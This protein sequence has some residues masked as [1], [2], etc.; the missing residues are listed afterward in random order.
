VVKGNK[1]GRTL[2][3]PTANLEVED[4]KLVPGNG[5]YAVSCELRATSPSAAEGLP[6][7]QHEPQ[8]TQKSSQ[9]TAHSPQLTNGMMNIGVRPTV[10]G[11]GR[12]I[13]VHLFDFNKDIYGQT[14]RVYI[15]KYLRGEQKFSGLEALKEQLA[16][17]KEAAMKA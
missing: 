16:K 14:L 10:G 6:Q 9:L 8:A 7:A 1:L 13:E 12:V 17:D 4:D 5:V 3:Y 15:K 11:I 2:G